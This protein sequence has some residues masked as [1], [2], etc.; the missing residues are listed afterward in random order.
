MARTFLRRRFPGLEHVELTAGD[1]LQVPGRRIRHVY[2]PVGSLVSLFAC[3]ARSGDAPVEVALI[4]ADGMVG[5]SLAQG[6]PV[7]WTR[8]VVQASGVAV[9]AS[10]A[11]FLVAL[12]HTPSLRHRVLRHC[13][14]LA[15]LFAQSAACSLNHSTEQRLARWL[16]MASERLGSEHIGLTQQ[17]IADA[18]SVR[19]TGVSEAAVALR[20]RGLIRYRRGVVEIVSRPRLITASCPCLG[21]Q[22]RKAR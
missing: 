6:D 5:A 3:T 13:S 21:L 19:R 11:A 4:G 20:R 15:F 16:L 1:V 2:F 18:L 12:E 22:A 17:L 10:T 7:A 14:D 8:A 9:R